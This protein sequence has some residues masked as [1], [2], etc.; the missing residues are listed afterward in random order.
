MDYNAISDSTS[1]IRAR[2]IRLKANLLLPEPEK[3]NEEKPLD[4]SVA[5]VKEFRAAL[6]RL[7]KSI[8]RFLTN[9]IFKES[10]VVEVPIATRASHDLVQDLEGSERSAET[11]EDDMHVNKILGDDLNSAPALNYSPA[12]TTVSTCGTTLSASIDSLP[13]LTSVLP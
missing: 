11:V 8:M 2:A 10:T 5:N 12:I 6:L 3:E 1:Q 9:P 7:N 4:L 13:F